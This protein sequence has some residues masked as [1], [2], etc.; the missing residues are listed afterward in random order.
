MAKPIT[1]SIIGGNGW[2][3]GFFL[4]IA[5]ALPDRFRVTGMQVRDAAAGEELEREWNVP[6]HRDFESLLDVPADFVVV[7]VPWPVAPQMLQEL[8]KR[9]IPALC[10]TPPAP[11]LEGLNSLY[12]L[13][14][15]GAKIQV[16]EQ[17]QFRPLHA[18]RISLA[19]SGRLGRV[20]QAQVSVAHGYHGIS[21]LRRYLQTGST[22]AL[23]RLATSNHLS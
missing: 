7:S 18:A 1:F 10:E 12:E 4:R 6:T 13:A 16:A 19:N 20:T 11:D 3:A 8:A 15:N 14:L 21:L 22:T 2:R 9:G 23:S 17:L 5:R